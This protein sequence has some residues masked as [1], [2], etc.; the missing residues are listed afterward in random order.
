MLGE[1]L[2]ATVTPFDV[3]GA[4]E[5]DRYRELCSFLVDNGSDGVVVNGTTGE[6]ST[7][8]DE[9]R[10]GLIEAAL[11][12]VGE[13]Y[14]ELMRDAEALAHD[15]IRSFSKSMTARAIAARDAELAEVSAQLEQARARI[16]TLEQQPRGPVWSRV[17]RRAR[18]R[19][20]AR[21]EARNRG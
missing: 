17:Y 2:T 11:D 19:L 14:G 7:L 6:A 5:L 8:S 10:I 12:A 9:E 15:A 18:L 13:R 4:V 20:G 3:E 16:T 21:H 1:V